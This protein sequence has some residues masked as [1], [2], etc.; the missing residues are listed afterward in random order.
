MTEPTISLEARAR[1][2][3]ALNRILEG[4]RRFAEGRPAP[5]VVT[6]EQR[7]A[8]LP[9]QEPFAIVLGCVDSRVPPEVV[10]DQGV[11]E[12]F[13]VRTAGHSLAGVALGSLE[14]GVRKLGVPL[15]AVMAHTGCGA[16]LAA[17]SADPIDG[18][19]G[20]LTGEVA[21][22]LHNVVGEDPVGATGANLDATVA[23]LRELHT[24]VTPDGDE[25]FVIGLLYDMES[26][27][28]IVEDDAGLLANA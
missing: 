10:M 14:F 24:L 27:L 2:A 18:H 23:A 19:L 8:L 6:P 21:S 26:G 25:A 13:T 9:A 5:H 11:G 28:L 1:A 15:V 17:L 7:K 12:L 16:V 22:R 4:N 20:E 3:E